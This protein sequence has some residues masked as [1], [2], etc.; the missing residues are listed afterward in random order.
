MARPMRFPV[1][2]PRPSVPCPFAS[3]TIEIPPWRPVGL[4]QLIWEQINR[5]VPGT[6]TQFNISSDPRNVSPVYL[7]AFMGNPLQHHGPQSLWDEAGPSYWDY[8]TSSWDH[9]QSPWDDL[10]TIWDNGES[11]W[12]VDYEPSNVGRPGP[13]SPYNYGTIL[14]PMGDPTFYSSYPGTQCPIG[15]LQIFSEAPAKVHLVITE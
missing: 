1:V 5:D 7:G 8:G 6:S 3:G 10:P 2:P 11:E 12:D 4:L 13:L 15:L 9:G 14:T